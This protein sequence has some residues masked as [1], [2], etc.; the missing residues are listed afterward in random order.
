[1]ID[2]A[3]EE[4]YDYLFLVD[5]DLIIHPET[6]NYLL[7]ANKDIISEVFWTKWEPNADKQPQVWISD[8]YKQWVQQR[9]ETLSEE[10]VVE[11]YQQ[12]ISKMRTPG[13]YEVGGLGACTLISRKAL[14]AGVNFKQIKNLSF[15]GE[16]RHFCIRAVAL[17]LSL[18]VDTHVPPLHLIQGF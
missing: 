9:G 17:G 16:D 14:Q 2:K 12:F 11:R 5:S 15:W 10:E 1:M 4:E 7:K 13:V 6:I 3:I 18:H 8:E